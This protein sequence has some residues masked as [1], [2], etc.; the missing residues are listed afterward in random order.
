[1]YKIIEVTNKRLGKKFTDFPNILYKNNENYVPA[2]SA[3]ENTVFNPKKNPVHEYCESIRF[4]AL[5]ENNKIVGR[6]AGIINHK[7]NDAKNEKVLRFSRLDM[8]DDI[9]VTELLFDTVIKWGKAK[10]MSTIIGPIGFTDLDLQGLLVEGFNEFGSFI[11]IY[12]DSYYMHHLERL[13]FVKDVD[14]LEKKIKWPTEVPE[15]IKKGAEI[16]QKRYGYRVVKPTSRKD[17]LIKADIAF[18]VYNK[19]FNDLY[20]FFPISEKV[21]HYYL[22]QVA[23]ILQLDYIWFIYDKTDEIVGFGVMMPSLAAA[24]KKNNGKLIP[25]GWL[26]ILKALKKHDVIDFYFIAVDPKHQ[27]KGVATLILNDGIIVGNKHNVKYAETGPELEE[28]HAIHAQ[29]KAFD[30]DEH[31]RRR[32]YKKAM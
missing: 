2:L 10:G 13:G 14:W 31:K 21:K 9:K 3:D 15:K 16:V 22:K 1:M 6:I 26:R 19:A 29:W 20:G 28:N 5:D 18:G 27:G 7:F 17:A 25:F 8:I 23:L 12:N 4:L 11:T 30:V 24:S 32:C